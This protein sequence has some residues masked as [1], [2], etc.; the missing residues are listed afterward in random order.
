MTQLYRKYHTQRSHDVAY[1][2][3][4]A[5]AMDT[6]LR[7]RLHLDS[8]IMASQFAPGEMTTNSRIPYLDTNTNKSH[9]LNSPFITINRF[10]THLMYSVF[11]PHYKK[12]VWI[13]TQ[14]CRIADPSMKNV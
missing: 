13:W 12:T 7:S 10:R 3:V 6:E 4:L 2:P 8:L 1:Q 11:V 5:K 9:Y 14:K